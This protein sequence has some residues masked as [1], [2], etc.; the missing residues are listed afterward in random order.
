MDFQSR[1]SKQ[2]LRSGLPA[3][4]CAFLNGFDAAYRIESD[5]TRIQSQT[6]MNLIYTDSL[7]L[8]DTL[9]KGK[10]TKDR[11]PMTDILAVRELNKR[12]ETKGIGYIKGN[13]ISANGLRKL[14]KNGV[15]KKLFD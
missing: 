3:K 7:Q 15:L 2:V 11:R 4:A 9:T 10:R 1:K 8:F 6:Y 12:S 5:F 13:D 14:K